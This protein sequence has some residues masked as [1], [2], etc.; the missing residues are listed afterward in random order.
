MERDGK[1]ES[2]SRKMGKGSI[3][4]AER[5]ERAEKESKINNADTLDPWICF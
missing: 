3:E 5:A 1:R 4:R 2:Q